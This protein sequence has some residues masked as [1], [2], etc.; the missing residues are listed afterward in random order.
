MPAG[1]SQQIDRLTTG[2][3]NNIND[4]VAGGLQSP[5][6]LA[7]YASQL[8]ERIALGNETLK[9]NSTIGVVYAGLFQY[10]QIDPAAV[11]VPARGGL[12]FWKDYE[13]AIVTTDA[14][15]NNLHAFAGVLLNAPTV[16]NFTFIQTLGK[17]FVQFKATITKATPAIGDLVVVDAAPSNAAD[18]PADATTLTGPL[19]KAWIGNAI[20]QTPVNGGLTLVEL[21]PRSFVF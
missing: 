14:A 2:Q 3:I 19:L 7:R 12:V 13:N 5:T 4:A 9:Y 20:L 1:Y 17:V 18:I 8:G 6:G 16:G 11:K 15:A 21:Q 10:V